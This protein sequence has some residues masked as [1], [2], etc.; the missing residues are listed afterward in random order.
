MLMKAVIL[1]AGVGNRLKPF[2]KATPKCLIEVQGTP[3]LSNA[4]DVLKGSG[5]DE[6]LLVVGHLREKIRHTVGMQWGPLRIR[7]VENTIYDRTNTSYSL[8]LALHHLDLPES[9]LILEG[10]VFFQADLLAKLIADQGENVTVLEPYHPT[11]D[12]TFVEIDETFSVVDWWHKSQMSDAF[13]IEDKYKTVNLHKFSRSFVKEVMLPVLEDE[14]RQSGGKS[15]LEYVMKKIVTDRLVPIKGLMTNG[16]KWAEIDDVEDLKRAE[17]MF[18]DGKPSSRGNREKKIDLD[19]ARSLHGGY[20][21]YDFI[22]FYYLYNSYFPPKELCEVLQRELPHLIDHYPSTHRVIAE[23]L[24]RWKREDYFNPENIVVG[25]GSSELIRILNGMVTKMTVPIPTFNEF[26]QLPEERLNLFLLNEEE[27]FRIDV[28]GLIDSIRKSKSDFAVLCNPNN[29]VGNLVSKKEIEEILK[30]GVNLIL[31]E[32]FIDWSGPENSCEDLVPIYKNLLIIK[33]LTKVAGTAGLRLGYLLTTNEKIREE[34]RSRLPIWNINSVTE[35]FVEL[36]PEFLREFENS[37]IKGKEDRSYL[38]HRLKELP[39][40]E[41][42]ESYANFIFCKTKISARKIGE[43]LFDRHH[44][45]IRDSLNQESLKR[46]RY[47]RVGVRT[48]EENDKLIS[49][50]MDV[51][52]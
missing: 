37:L 34:V 11:L 45:L 13:I 24:S 18:S 40:L 5:V 43:D 49:A 29:P 41:P 12:G 1:V 16:L 35:R 28:K 32:A 47:I 30:S 36:F 48:K 14:V 21:R 46:D 23:L 10:D 8:W 17:Q 39:Y 25:N 44:I 22:D 42:Y 51:R 31:D 3:I 19:Q 4:L 52:Q 20:W 9:L 27:K 33:S 15:P 38:H 2:T 7:Y 26:T 50:L 6:V